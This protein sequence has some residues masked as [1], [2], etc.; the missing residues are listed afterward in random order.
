MAGMMPMHAGSAKAGG[1]PDYAA[2]P[3]FRAR[4]VGPGLTR[5]LPGGTIV[6]AAFGVVGAERFHC[7]GVTCAST[8]TDVLRV[9]HY[10]DRP[11]PDSGA[12]I[13][14]SACSYTTTV[15]SVT[16]F[17][18]PFVAADWQLVRLAPNQCPVF[19]PAGSNVE[20]AWTVFGG[21]PAL[22][23]AG[24]QRVGFAALYFALRQGQ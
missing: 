4:V 10:D 13:Q 9:F 7:A 24:D 5:A 14:N 12:E 22:P 11:G 20:R 23:F 19:G 6:G 18:T 16:P 2:D 3:T 8:G 17:N 21:Q 1:V 15:A